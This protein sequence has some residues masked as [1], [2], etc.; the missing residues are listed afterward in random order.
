MRIE[1]QCHSNSQSSRQVLN[2]LEEI[3]ADERLPISVELTEAEV[4]NS[5]VVRFHASGADFQRHIQ[6]LQLEP[7]Q[8]EER[9]L[10][11]RLRNVVLQKWHDYAIH[12][13]AHLS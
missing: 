13:L 6:D 1:L 10:H 8:Q 2:L 5:P 12:P 11:E 7:M 4:S 3:I 9:K